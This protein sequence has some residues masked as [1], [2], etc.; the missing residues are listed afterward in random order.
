[1]T[2][3]PGGA[4]MRDWFNRKRLLIAVAIVAIIGVSALILYFYFG[5]VSIL[6]GQSHPAVMLPAPRISASIVSQDVL[7]HNDLK[8]LVP[9]VLIGYFSSNATRIT[10]NV[11]LFKYPPPRRTFI[12]N[13]SNECFN[14]GNTAAIGAALAVDLERYG[15]ILGPGNL[16]TISPSNVRALPP[17]SILI[18]LNGLLPSSLLNTNGSSNI[19]SLTY[20]LNE[21]TSIIYVGQD[22][23]RMLLPD[24]IVTPTP[25]SMRAAYLSTMSTRIL[26][27]SNPA[28]NSFYFGR[29][30]FVFV[31]GS[32][33]S[34]AS[35]ANIYNGSI[36]AFANTPDSWPANQSG[37]DIAKAVRG[38]FW[39]PRYA[40]GTTTITLPTAASSGSRFGVVLD[41]MHAQTGNAFVAA[42]SQRGSIRAAIS[43]NA[44]YP[45]G[46][47]NNTYQYLFSKPRLYQN[48]TVVIQNYTL[49]NQSIPIIFTVYTGLSTPTNITPSITIY[50][51]NLSVVDELPL[52]YMHNVPSNFTFL[53][54]SRLALP[55]GRQYIIKLHDFSG[56]EFGA[57]LFNV[58]PALLSPINQNLTNGS[59]VFSVTSQKL[60]LT[61][62]NYSISLNNLYSESGT[63]KNGFLEYYLPKGTPE[64]HGN[65][66]FTLNI[67][68]SKSYFTEQY[69]PVPFGINEQ[70]IEIAAVAVIMLLMIV[71]VKAPNRDEFYIDVPNLPEEKKI[72][73]K[74]KPADVVGIFDKLNAQYHW[75]YMPLSKAEIKSAISTYIKVNNISVALTY[76]N[77]DRII[78][79]L[80]ANKYLITADELYAPSGWADQSKHD[81]EYLAIFK[82][83]RIYLVT[84]AYAFTDLDTS[85]NADIVATLRNDKKYIVIY[86]K[87]DKFQKVPIYTGSKTYIVFLNSY[88]LEEFKDRLYDSSTMQA[89]ELKMYI[90][91]GYV[92][93][94]DA[95]NPDPMLS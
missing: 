46:T 42:A 25:L 30:T 50:T 86:S 21:H 81:V 1:M 62:I 58:S 67:M 75:K 5:F 6:R 69:Y 28:N 66:N 33:Y 20:L 43:A 63:I 49:T 56:T 8:E 40:Y 60:P 85:Q 61:N 19:S 32:N 78:D 39:L 41:A 29:G 57:A 54:Y 38:L 51:T 12:L 70:Y 80:T 24:S 4:P 71:L 59:F 90:G 76:N 53:N 37:A 34:T 15:L 14:C 82:K 93:L 36:F 18:I 88:K 72:P 91:A 11:S 87:T 23:S 47:S 48:G 31:D 84:H 3:M 64:V 65:L 73:I 16:S 44:T 94:V 79:L 55:P 13:I 10:A 35:Y 9:Y 17:N 27:N 26:P 68:G 89:E 92:K 2:Y 45:S 7:S 52:P 74:L 22:F 77:I 95:D 83:L